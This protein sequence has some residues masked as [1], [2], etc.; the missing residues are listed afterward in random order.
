[1]R[2]KSV[3]PRE[4]A[5]R[6]VEDAIAHYLG[7]GADAAASGFID[8]LEKA[9]RH[10]ARHPATGSSRH[11]HELNLPGLRA[12]PVARYPY[13]L[14]YV[15]RPEHIDVWRVLH[16]QRDIPGWMQEPETV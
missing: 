2:A 4:Q 7:Q 16:S 11:A 13:I 9:Y 6:D 3:V 14:F 10:L 12:W 1:M 15:E 8:A 5:H